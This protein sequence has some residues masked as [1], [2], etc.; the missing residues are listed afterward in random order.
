M[1]TLFLQK[2][3][4]LKHFRMF[5]QELVRLKGHALSSALLTDASTQE[6]N[7]CRHIFNKLVELLSNNKASATKQH[8]KAISSYYDEALYI[9]V[10]LAD[11]VFLNLRWTG[12]N[13]WQ[14]HLL[15][16]HFFNTHRA[17]EHFFI[18]L[19]MLLSQNN[20]AHKDLAVL[21]LWALGL[22]FVGKFD[23]PKNKP[24]LEQYK[25]QLCALVHHGSKDALT[26][27]DGPA[28]LSPGAYKH[29]L[30]GS[31]PSHLPSLQ[32]WYRCLYG[33]IGFMLIVSS[34]IWHYDLAEIRD[35]LQITHTVEVGA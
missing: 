8:D 34:L 31:R 29:I 14:D 21:Y 7:A 26:V 35:I 33:T 6:Q 11:E 18:K 3:L 15:E 28:L 25:K 1:D 12:K 4:V 22:N 10:A 20:A 2:S 16:V 27:E 30:R 17:G 23:A 24:L 19:D 32:F 13:A 5:Y 9:M